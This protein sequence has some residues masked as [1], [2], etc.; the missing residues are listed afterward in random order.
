[1]VEVCFIPD[2]YA[3]LLAHAE[4]KVTSARTQLQAAQGGLG[5]VKGMRQPEVE[6]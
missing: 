4:A 3:Y 5:N 6:K 2:I 1:V